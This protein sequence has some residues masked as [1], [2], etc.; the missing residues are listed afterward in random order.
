MYIMCFL[1][2]EKLYYKG[3]YLPKVM[4]YPRANNTELVKVFLNVFYVYI[5]CFLPKKKRYKG[6]FVPAVTIRK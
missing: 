5:M 2:K 4:V 6:P 3:P 1:P